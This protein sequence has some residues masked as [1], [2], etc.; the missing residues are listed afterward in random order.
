MITTLTRTFTQIPKCP[1]RTL[2]TGSQTDK[3]TIRDAF[4]ALNNMFPAFP[5]AAPVQPANSPSSVQPEN[6]PSP[7]STVSS[8]EIPPTEDPLL[9]YIASMFLHHGHRAKASRITSR[10]LLYIR[11]LTNSP[12]LPILR[13][14]VL[15]ASPAVR[16]MMHRQ[17]AKNIA[18]PI[19]LGEKQRT[20]FAVKWIL[21]ASEKQKGKTAEE[22]LAREIIAISQGNSDALKKKMEAH[23]FAM[24]NRCAFSGAFFLLPRLADS[25]RPGGTHAPVFEPGLVMWRYGLRRS[26][27]VCHQALDLT[28]S[29]V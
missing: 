2:L 28:S 16:T 1:S 14:A 27:P 15:A 23:R 10:T 8:T 13:E 22:R 21:E 12:P 4:S 17:G 29:I 25:I 3:A 5:G 19:A 9:H 20:R 18:R 7:N 6:P 24:V 11:N 26:P